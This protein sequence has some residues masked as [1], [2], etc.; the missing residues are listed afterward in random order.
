MSAQLKHNETLPTVRFGRTGMNITR[1]GFGSWAVGGGDWAVGWGDQDDAAS[2]AAI[3]HAVSRGINWIDTAAIYGLGRSEEVVAAALR[4][5]PVSERPYIF[6][7]CGMI[8]DPQN[9]SEM[10]KRVGNPASLRRE[11]EASLKRLNVEA[12]DLYQMHWPA[13][14]GTPLEAYW[15][16]LLDMKTEGK[17]RAAGLSNH[18]VEQLEAAEKLGHVDTLQPP[19]S[20]IKRD[21]ADKELAWCAAHDTGV[22][23][24]SPMQ[25]GLLTGAFSK[26]RVANLPENDWRSRNVEFTEKLDANLQVAEAMK[27]VAA[28]HG[29]STAAVAVA[30]TLAWPGVTA[31]IVGARSPQQVDGWIAAASLELTQGDMREIGEVIKR[32]GAGTGPAAPV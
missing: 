1:A 5:I 15:Q 14:D 2:I 28:R 29:V 8:G 19:F 3:R 20:A 32:S 16:A 13:K 27:T 24:Y 23:V 30:W 9:P 25:A 18:S 31:A 21:V 26:D 6:T 10:P 4:D 12:I 17:I 22:I 11:V 7:K